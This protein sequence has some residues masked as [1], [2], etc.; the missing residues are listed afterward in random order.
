MK[1][2]FRF[3]LLALLLIRV[4]F[5]ALSAAEGPAS[6]R[7]EYTHTADL[8]YGRKFGMALTLDVFAPA[9]ANGAGILFLMS[10][11]WVSNQGPVNARSFDALLA[12]G[13]TVFTVWHGSQ[14]K[15]VVPEIMQDV[16][17]AARFVRA[18]ARRFGIDPQRIGVTGTSSG[19]HLSLLLGLMGGPGPADAKDPIDR[20]SSAVQAVACFCPPTDFANWTKAG[21]DVLIVN[22]MDPKYAGA[23]KPQ[24]DTREGRV[25]LWREWSPIR[26]VKAGAPPIFVIHGDADRTV[27]IYQARAFA[28]AC[29]AAGVTHALV[30]REGKDHTWPEMTV[31]RGQF[32]D[33]FDRTLNAK[34]N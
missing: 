12:R 16:H 23:W 7:T 13:Y 6:S 9:R 8:V 10:G 21:D 22:P 34:T 4:S 19:G 5:S 26:F 29:R 14:P 3:Q 24:G 11:G 31:D 1:I 17:R 20:E 2:K 28:E 30:V 25:Q 27:P 32:A 18:N 33:W 15:Y